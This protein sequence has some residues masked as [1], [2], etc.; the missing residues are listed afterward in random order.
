MSRPIAQGISLE[1]FRGTNQSMKITTSNDLQYMVCGLHLCYQ[2]CNWLTLLYK[3]S[4][5]NSSWT[6]DIF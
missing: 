5:G 1:K 3:Y 6:T 4:A 2:V